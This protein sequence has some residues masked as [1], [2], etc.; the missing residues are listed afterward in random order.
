MEADV[1]NGKTRLVNSVFQVAD[2]TRP[3]MSVS[4]ICVHG[5]KCIFE[6][7]QAT[8]VDKDMHPK[9]V[10]ER[11]GGIYVT[12]MTLKAPMPFQRPVP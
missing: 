4:Q 11:R 10:C 1:G 7:E 9:F 3:L 5:F 2:L 12:P 6:K 8:V